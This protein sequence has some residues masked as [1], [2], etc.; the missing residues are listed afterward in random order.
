MPLNQNN[1]TKRLVL[2]KMAERIHQMKRRRTEESN[3]MNT[4]KTFT[5]NYNILS[6]AQQQR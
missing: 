2:A 5:R 6:A 1:R 3:K 4:Q